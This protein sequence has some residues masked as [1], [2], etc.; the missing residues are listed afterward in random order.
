VIKEYSFGRIKINDQVYKNDV[1]VY[2][3]RVE[4]DWWRDQGHL[5][6]EQD[7]TEVMKFEPEFLVVGTGANGVMTVPKQLKKM[8]QEQT[9]LVVAKTPQAIE[10]FNQLLAEDKKVVGA[11]HLTC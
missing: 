10:K 7:L 6:Q 9:N 2:P 3:N 8:L 4:P 1:I 11:F 5:L